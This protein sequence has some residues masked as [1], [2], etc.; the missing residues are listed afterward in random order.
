M[1]ECSGD[2]PP[3]L[4]GLHGQALFSVAFDNDTHQW[5]FIFTGERTLQVSSRWRLVSGQSI[6]LGSEDEGQRFGNGTDV[7]VK[8]RT[9]ALLKSNEVTA[10]TV[11]PFGD[12]AVRIGTDLT[13][14]V[15]NGSASY[16][17]WQL[18]G[19]GHRHV[20]AQGGGRVV[21]SEDER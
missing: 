7:D 4:S 10:A 8:Q 16:E 9:E 17:G 12:L 15:F 6:V 2:M 1:A 11:G 19:P 21:C 14:Q 13:L 20:V 18:F 3:S 5:V